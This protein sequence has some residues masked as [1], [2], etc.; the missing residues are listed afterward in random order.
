MLKSTFKILLYA[1][2]I[3]L[4]ILFLAPT[5]LSSKLAKEVLNKEI[6]KRWK[7]GSIQVE[8]LS[9]S[10]FGTQVFKDLHVQDEKN[11]SF[12]ASS[13]ELRAPLFRV[14][15]K[16]HV[17]NVSIEDGCVSFRSKEGQPFL[18]S[19]INGDIKLPRKASRNLKLDIKAIVQKDPNLNCS[20][21]LSSEGGGS[22]DIQGSIS[23][24]RLGKSFNISGATGGL[25][26]EL[27]NFPLEPL[28]Q[29]FNIHGENRKM[30]SA[31]IGNMLNADAEVQLKQGDGTVVANL[32][33]DKSEAF[34]DASL[35]DNV[36]SL[37]KPFVGKIEVSRDLAYP[38]LSRLNPLLVNAVG[39][40]NPITLTIP[41]KDVSIPLNPF[42]IE[43]MTIPYGSFTMGKMILANDGTLYSL[44]SMLG[45]RE[46]QQMKRL[47]VWFTPQYFS[48]REGI[49]DAQRIDLL[50][51]NQLHMAHWGQVNL[52]N[53]TINL[54]MGLTA[55]ALRRAFGIKNTP[56]QQMLLIRINGPM[57][58]PRVDTSG[59]AT[60]VATML[61][62][63]KTS[64][65]GSLV[66]GV[67]EI[68]GAPTPLS[69]A[70]PPTTQPFPWEGQ[71]KQ[72]SPSSEEDAKKKVEKKVKAEVK[73]FFKKL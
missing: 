9:L 44:I 63:D 32:S 31:L 29:F 47:N 58:N 67:L 26:A 37:N 11:G 20:S 72:E 45:I 53:E 43:K 8:K 66:K 70:P 4:I 48:I 54:T 16:R 7:K 30:I 33:S 13:L 69:P 64:Q 71:V 46:L 35:K 65:I 2:S 14:L 36:L 10:W 24:I 22:I 51:A 41:E 60:Q 23:N 17:K 42:R 73:K 34:V 49:V 56:S 61:A 52:K 12:H 62:L 55:Q 1:I 28:I 50:I 27:K 15:W 18:L 6:N 57:K 3:L 19:H 39:A 5:I 59:I 68:A 38:I 40:E 21:D 25:S